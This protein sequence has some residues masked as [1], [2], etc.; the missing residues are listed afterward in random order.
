MCVKQ[1]VED[2]KYAEWLLRWKL[3]LKFCFI[4]T[5]RFWTILCTG[6]IIEFYRIWYGSTAGCFSIV[7]LYYRHCQSDFCEYKKKA[8]F[9]FSVS[10]WLLWTDGACYEFL[11]FPKEATHVGCPFMLLNLVRQLDQ[12][13]K[14]H[15]QPCYCFQL[16]VFGRVNNTTAKLLQ[17][18]WARFSELLFCSN[19]DCRCI[20]L[21]QWSGRKLIWLVESIIIIFYV[22]F[23]IESLDK[24]G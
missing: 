9:S 3:Y 4:W 7:S 11:F 24:C 6:N 23:S 18:A 5:N 12:L 10:F 8:L 2:S 19:L 13:G 17:A 14:L 21:N 20:Y 16:Y 1:E 15:N 22:L